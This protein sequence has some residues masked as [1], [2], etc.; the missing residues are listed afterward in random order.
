ML[1]PAICRAGIPAAFALL[2]APLWAQ[3]PVISTGA[4]GPSV[5]ET[6]TTDPFPSPRFGAS[7]AICGR[8]AMASIPGDLATE[9]NEFGR[10]AVFE[11]RNG[12]WIRTA[13]FIGTAEAGGTF[14]IPMDIEGNQAVIGGPKAIYL[15]E[16][17]QSGWAQAAKVVLGPLDTL[18]G[19]LD[20]DHGQIFAAVAHQSGDVT[21]KQVNVYAQ[22]VPGKLTRTAFIRPRFGLDDGDFGASLQADGRLLVVGSPN[23]NGPGAAYVYTGS[24]RQ[25]A[26]VDRLMASDATSNDRFGAS[27]GIRDGVIVVGAPRADLGLPYEGMGPLLGNVYVFRRASYGWYES[28]KINELAMEN[29]QVGIGGNVSIGRGMLAL[30]QDDNRF[31]V[32]S[33]QRALVYDWVDGSFRFNRVVISTGEG[34]VPDIDMAGRSLI[35]SMQRPPDIGNYYTLGSAGI[36]EFGP[37]ESSGTAAP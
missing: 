11:K 14:G 9:P 29:P 24:G 19:K 31:P 32:R 16:R 13:T 17:R 4:I 7:V 18:F 8:I 35:A 10:V 26:K 2:A 25:W 3:S 15:F 30:F 21:V 23:N 27:V 36:W 20:I 34:V 5:E 1:I 37:Y 22:L 33:T 28:Q 6:G 12:E